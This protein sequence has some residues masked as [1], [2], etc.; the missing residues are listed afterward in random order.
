MDG[1]ALPVSPDHLYKRLG[2]AHAPWLVDVRRREAFDADEFLIIGAARRLPE[3]VADW[4]EALP[5]GRPVVAYCAHGH[6]LS[7][8]VAASLRSRGIAATHL[9]G[10]I[11]GWKERRF[12]TRRKRGAAETKWVTREH[13]KI[14][15]IACPWLISRFV[16]PDAEF[17]YVPAADVAKVAADVGGTPYDI[18]DVEFGHVGDRCSFDAIIR[19]YEIADPALDLLATIVRGADTSRPDLTP[20]CEGLLAISYGLS[21]NF[22]DDHEMLKHGMVMYDALY[23]WCR[24]QTEKQRSR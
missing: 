3:S 9:E 4:Q 5:P 17:M 14:D 10:G 6:E 22:P 12:P 8:G 23:T 1:N 15:R 20:Q 19:A 7:Q 13:P 2:T 21:G 11:A 16:N 24:L 18:K